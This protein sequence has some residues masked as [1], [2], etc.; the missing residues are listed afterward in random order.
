MS[1]TEWL[2]Y[3]AGLALNDFMEFYVWDLQPLWNF[4]VIDHFG[5]TVWQIWE[6]SGVRMCGYRW[7]HS[8]GSYDFIKYVVEVDTKWLK[9][10]LSSRRSCA[11]RL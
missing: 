10:T 4:Y 5:L 7:L 9:L 3:F 2:M 6:F 8:F 1:D 11:R